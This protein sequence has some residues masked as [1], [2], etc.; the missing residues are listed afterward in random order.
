MMRLVRTS[1]DFSGFVFLAGFATGREP[2]FGSDPSRWGVVYL[3]F[4]WGRRPRVAGARKPTL[5]LGGQV[6]GLTV[7]SRGAGYESS[8]SQP[9]ERSLPA[10]D[11]AGSYEAQKHSTVRDDSG[12][13]PGAGMRS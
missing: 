10:A 3:F 2:A 6:F 13:S 12:T 9:L 4:R 1:S 7:W 11:V 5:E 8:V